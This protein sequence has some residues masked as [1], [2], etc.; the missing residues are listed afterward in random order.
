MV[1]GLRPLIPAIL[2]QGSVVHRPHVMPSREQVYH[3]TLG[4]CRRIPDGMKLCSCTRVRP[5]HHL[6]RCTVLKLM[7]ISLATSL[8]DRPEVSSLTSMSCGAR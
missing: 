7:P 4:A 1:Y 5:S 8:R 6:G 2:V 3:G